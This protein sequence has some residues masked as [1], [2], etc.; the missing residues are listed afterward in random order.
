MSHI[1]YAAM[2]ILDVLMILCFETV[3]LSAVAMTN[4]PLAA[5]EK[6]QLSPPSFFEI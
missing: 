5:V 6:C 2:L 3:S 4:R 1:G